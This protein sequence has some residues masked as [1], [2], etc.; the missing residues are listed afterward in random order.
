[1]P[2]TSK[3]RLCVNDGGGPKGISMVVGMGYSRQS[4]KSTRLTF[5]TDGAWLPIPDECGLGGFPLTSRPGSETG[6][7]W[8]SGGNVG[9]QVLSRAALLKEA[10][11]S[12]E[13]VRAKALGVP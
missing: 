10:G 11:S 6:I 12:L 1:M 4:P 3:V 13:C 8:E 7:D 2:R 9:R 5:A